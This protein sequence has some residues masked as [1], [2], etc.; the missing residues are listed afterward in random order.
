MHRVCLRPAPLTRSD[1]RWRRILVSDLHS[2]LSGRPTRNASSTWSAVVR[3]AKMSNKRER[4]PRS[5]RNVNVSR[6]RTRSRKA[7]LVTTCDGARVW[8]GA[9]QSSDSGTCSC[10]SAKSPRHY[11]RS[12]LGEGLLRLW[13]RARCVE[14]NRERPRRPCDRGSRAWGRP[15]VLRARCVEQHQQ[16]SA[17]ITKLCALSWAFTHFLRVLGPWVRVCVWF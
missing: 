3:L 7:R 6:T 17:K 5:R 16:R 1:G 12:C 13:L 4:V 9:V 8:G 2:A 14:Q 15:A 10:T 11:P